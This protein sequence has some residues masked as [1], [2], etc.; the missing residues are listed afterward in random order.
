[1]LSDRVGGVV[2]QNLRR[3]GFPLYSLPHFSLPLLTFLFQYRFWLAAVCVTRTF[4]PLARCESF[5]DEFPHLVVEHNE[6]VGGVK[7]KNQ[8]SMQVFRR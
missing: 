4:G 7:L 3:G 6:M 5:F 1:M 2:P 8:K